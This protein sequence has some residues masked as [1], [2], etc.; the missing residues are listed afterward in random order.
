LRITEADYEYPFHTLSEAR[1]R[2]T[3]IAVSISA[4]VGIDHPMSKLANAAATKI[5]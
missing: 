4:R 5:E 2:A 1:S 3:E